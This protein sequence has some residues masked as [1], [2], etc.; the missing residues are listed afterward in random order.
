MQVLLTQTVEKLGQP[1][2]VVNVAPGYARNYLLP[3]GLA[4]EPTPHNVQR[5]QKTREKRVTEMKEREEQAKALK[6][7][8]DGT[9]LTF[10]RK[11]H[12]KK[13][14]SSVRPEEIASQLSEQF[15]AEIEK[16]RVRIESPIEALGRHPVKIELY[17]DITA[18]IRVEVVEESPSSHVG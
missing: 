3:K 9:V 10:Y 11:S 15:R 12:D 16:G 5:F 6:Q 14:Y 13:I 7:K 8:L 18:E 1:G 2:D 17:K 4:V